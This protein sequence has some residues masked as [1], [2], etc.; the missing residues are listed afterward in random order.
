MIE[1]LDLLQG[2]K[3]ST[4]ASIQRA[5][6]QDM[7]VAIPEAERSARQI[8]RNTPVQPE[9]DCA[10]EEIHA[11]V[12]AR[13]SLLVEAEEKPTAAAVKRA[14]LANEFVVNCLR[15]AGVPYGSQFLSEQDSILELQ[16]CQDASARIAALTK[17]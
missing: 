9:R 15:P 16:R 1:A 4:G 17:R 2:T 7:H 6:L 3:F 12:A 5:P 13:D 14:R 8:S 10:A 11:Y